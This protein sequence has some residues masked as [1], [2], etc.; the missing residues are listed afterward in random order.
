MTFDEE[1]KKL[2]GPG[3]GGG[4][5]KNVGARN[6]AITFACKKVCVGRSERKISGRSSVTRLGHFLKFCAT[7]FLAKNSANIW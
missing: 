1:V 4:R 3:V 6:T 7:N 5:K 2:N